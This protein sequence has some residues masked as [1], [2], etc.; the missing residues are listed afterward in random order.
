LKKAFGDAMVS[1]GL[2]LSLAADFPAFRLS[3]FGHCSDD[4]LRAR[5][6]L[7]AKLHLALVSPTAENRTVTPLRRP[8]VELRTREHLTADEVEA[9]MA[10]Q[11]AS[12][13][14]TRA[15]TREQQA[16]RAFAAEMVAPIGYIRRRGGGQGALS[17]SR[18]EELARELQVSTQVVMYQAQNNRISV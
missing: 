5:G 13:L 10:A 7:M 14:V 11:D 4:Q 9:L 17:S 6:F 18:V 16:S 12:R 2:L 1:A 3:V 8:N 15:R